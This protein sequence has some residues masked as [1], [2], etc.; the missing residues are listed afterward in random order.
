MSP[1]TCVPAIYVF[2][3]FCWG[4]STAIKWKVRPKFFWGVPPVHAFLQSSLLVFLA[5]S[6][7]VTVCTCVRLATNSGTV[8]QWKTLMALMIHFH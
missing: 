3:S 4:F 6:Q 1:A 5:H 7:L 2:Q 8:S